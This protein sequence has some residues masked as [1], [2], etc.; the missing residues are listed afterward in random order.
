MTYR[1]PGVY[2]EEISTLPPSVAGVATAIPAFIGY[3]KESTDLNGNPLTKVPK[4]INTLLEYEQLFGGPN[5]AKFTIDIVG[6]PKSAT[7]TFT[8]TKDSTSDNFVLYYAL[9][10]Y[11]DN[12]GGSCYVVSAGQYTSEGEIPASAKGDLINALNAIK[13]EDEP[14]LLVVPEAAK[15]SLDHYKDV[16]NHALIQCA[17][18][19]DRFAILD[20]LETDWDGSDFRPKVA[21]EPSTTKYGAAYTPWL[22]TSISYI[23]EEK[24]VVVNGA[25]ISEGSTL[26]NLQELGMTRLYNEIKRILA[27]QWITLPP[28]PAIAGIYVRTDGNRGVWKAPANVGIFSV[29]EPARLITNEQQANLN[30]DA[31]TG[32]SINVIRSFAERG[33]LVWGAR[34]LAGNDNEWRYV[35]VRRLFIFIEESLQK[36]TQFAVFE[37]NTPT[38]WLKIKGMIESFLFGLWQQGALAG[39]DPESA[40]FVNVGLGKTMTPD[41]VLQGKMIVEIGL[42]AVRPAEFIILRFSHKLQEA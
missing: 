10:L 38:T 6:D 27:N 24:N 41:D 30:V 17:T 36:A 3:T 15:L 23:F 33:T 18:L 14:T 42:A 12:G 1:V 4:R 32:K 5:P 40:Y 28:S 11:F 7:P 13:L 20:L 16:C 39:P 9:K 35:N 26:A 22:K 37:S 29:N 2:V 25:G 34:T 19:K 21:I 31:T 8:I